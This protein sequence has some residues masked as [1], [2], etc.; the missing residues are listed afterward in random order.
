MSRSGPL[1]VV[2]WGPF[3]IPGERRRLERARQ[4]VRTLLA[5]ADVLRTDPSR[6][7]VR[8]PYES[9]PERERKL[10]VAL[11]R[12]AEHQLATARNVP[13]IADAAASRNSMTY[14]EYEEQ[15]LRGLEGEL[16][17][18][19]QEP[20]V[21]LGGLSSTPKHKPLQ[22]GDYEVILGPAARALFLELR[23]RE[24]RTLL[25]N[26][27]RSEL[28]DPPSDLQTQFTVDRKNYNAVPL[29]F[30]GIMAVYRNMTPAELIRI[31]HRREGGARHGVYVIDLL[32]AESA[33]FSPTTSEVPG[34]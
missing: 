20:A 12:A 24:D 5:R 34:K 7:R 11:V 15:I 30:N 21:A 9:V 33:F 28:G 18:T 19:K 31:A 13:D 8:S 10:K 6:A 29:S 3:P 25:A 2:G 16:S 26:A 14:R 23:R 22:R 1:R 27:L 32:R 17:G 4:E